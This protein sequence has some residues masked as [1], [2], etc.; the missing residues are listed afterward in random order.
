M[1]PVAS[2][3]DE[4]ANQTARFQLAE[5]FI[6]SGQYERAIPVLQDLMTEDST[7]HVFYVK[8]KESY[9]AVKRYDSAIDLIDQKIRSSP[10]SPV[11]WS[12]KARFLFLADRADEARATWDRALETAPQARSTYRVVE[13]SMLQARLYEDA[14]DILLLGRTRLSDNN[15]F[16]QELGQLYGL[17]SQHDLAMKEYLGLLAD[18]ER[19]LSVVRN[20]VL[21]FSSQPGVLAAGVA[22]TKMMVADN[23]TNRTFRELLAWLLLESDEY[24][25]ALNAT[26]AL[27]RLAGQT[28][29]ELFTFAGKA[30]GA[31]QYNIAL[32]AYQDILDRYAE[33]VMAPEAQ[34]GIGDMYLLQSE[35]VTATDEINRDMSRNA[36]DAYITFL[37]AYPT[38]NRVA[39][40]ILEA[41]KIL[42]D[43]LGDLD[44]ARKYI[45]RLKEEFPTR[46][47]TD[48]ADYLLAR[49]A[50]QEGNL[51]EALSTL[52]SLE[53]RLRVGD[54]AE[55]ARFQRSMVHF[56]RGEFEAAKTFVDVLKENTSTD[57]ANNAIEMVI[58]LNESMGPD[59][60]NAP[61]TKL[62]EAMLLL[63]Q[64]DS[65][66]AL[67]A[68]DSLLLH[69]PA[70][71]T[72]ASARFVKAEIFV[73]DGQFEEAVDELMQI[74]LAHPRSYLCDKSIFQAAELST[75]FLGDNERAIELY[76]RVVTEYPGSVFASEARTR[77]RLIRGDIES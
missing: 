73:A 25:D 70:H 14:I 11:F 71:A 38:N 27:D 65:A 63:E 21:R 74:P 37:N 77:A 2:A 32:E 75:K 52:V 24:E 48:S 56:Y 1:I 42:I 44:E 68:I 33:S 55:E 67:S 58:L 28:G 45:A 49:L 76:T 35:I 12:E 6:R 3:Q 57:I 10:A 43:P 61:L 29:A 41:A 51:T 69:Y 54:L 4:E 60:T 9:E 36:L 46:R 64:K 40:V 22:E 18:D 59:S 8:L 16:H 31:G 62:A 39:E 20:H 30:A 47:E 72:A 26:R 19:Q 23:P 13:Q 34:K 53:D 5:S 7:S 50:I 17:T 66:R 15:L